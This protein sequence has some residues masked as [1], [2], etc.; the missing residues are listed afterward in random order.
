M[1]EVAFVVDSMLV[2]KIESGLGLV[3]ELVEDKL[4][5]RRSR[6]GRGI[7]ICEY[8]HEQWQFIPHAVQAASAG[9]KSDLEP[10]QARRCWS[11]AQLIGIGP[12]G[13]WRRWFGEWLGDEPWSEAVRVCFLQTGDIYN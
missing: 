12:S 7:S 6:S 8:M 1:L 3:V 9:R 13:L 4:I 5:S 10:C 2:W 11:E